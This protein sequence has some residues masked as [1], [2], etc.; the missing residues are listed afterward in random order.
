MQYRG[1]TP[2]SGAGKRRI[3]A[4]RKSVAERLDDGELTHEEAFD[5]AREALLRI[6]TAAQKSRRELEQALARKGYPESVVMP[7]LERFDE[8][9]LVDDAAYAGTIVRTRHGE[10]GLARRAISAELRRRGID[11]DT[12]T[13]ALDQIDPD[14]ERA[15]GARLA[16]KLVTRTRGLDRDVRVRRA[17]GSLARKG[18]APGLAFELV[19]EA[20]AA[21]GEDT[22]DL[23]Y[24]D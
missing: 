13:E 15:A 1:Q 7:L 4:P 14:D 3:R 22:G 16:E 20:L 11:E 6:L 9:G 18:Y 17:V 12:A 19:R 5:A 21:D 2:G 8:V 10:R 24:G 23:P